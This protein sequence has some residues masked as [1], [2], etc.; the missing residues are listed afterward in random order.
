MPL[1]HAMY[2]LVSWVVNISIYS[3]SHLNIIYAHIDRYSSIY[4]YAY[5][6]IQINSE[7]IFNLKN[8]GFYTNDALTRHILNNSILIG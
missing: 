6:L 5:W 3:I 8:L 7:E 1:H 2:A 4:I